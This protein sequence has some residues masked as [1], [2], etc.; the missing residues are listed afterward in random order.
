MRFGGIVKPDNASSQIAEGD[1]QRQQNASPEMP[2]S[3]MVGTS[4]SAAT[5][6]TTRR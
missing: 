4:G 1:E 5:R 3:P 2:S 6:L